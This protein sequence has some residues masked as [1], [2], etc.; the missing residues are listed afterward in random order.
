MTGVLEQMLL[1]DAISILFQAIYDLSPAVPAMFAV[2]ALS[3]GPR[4]THFENAG[5]LFDY[6]R[7]RGEEVRMDRRCVT[8]ALERASQLTGRP[9]TSINI[10]ATTLVRDADF[11][12]FVI[13]AAH[14]AG[15][16]TNTLILEIVE[17]AEAS[18]YERLRASLRRLRDAGIR[19]A[20]DDLGLG[21][22]NH[23]LFLEVRP[24]FVKIDRYFVTN[25]DA[26]RD[27]KAVI[28]SMTQLAH[29]FGAVVIAEGVETPG[30]LAAVRA[31]GIDLVQGFLFGRP[32]LQPAPLYGAWQTD[33]TTT[34]TKRSTAQSR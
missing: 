20:L 1:P 2:E 13:E 31:L 34:S 27:R 4:G 10:H 30:E 22:C 5:V 3:R 25:C 26:D 33:N 7:L 23:Q 17:K 14:A 21:N 9:I 8:A 16:E 24:D 28:R 32:Q 19:I 11:P 6:V 18:N 12:E 15:I 29:D